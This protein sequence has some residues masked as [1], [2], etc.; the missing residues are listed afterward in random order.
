MRLWAI[1]SVACV[2]SVL[3]CPWQALAVVVWN[4]WTA[5]NEVLCLGPAAE[6]IWVGTYG[7]LVSWDRVSRAYTKFDTRDGLADSWILDVVE[8]D[9]GRVWV[10]TRGGL[11]Y[12]VGSSIFGEPPST[13]MGAGYIERLEKDPSGAIFCG[14]GCRGLL[15]YD[16]EGWHQDTLGYPMVNLPGVELTCEGERRLWL[17]VNAH[18]LCHW[19]NGV[20]TWFEP[21]G[22]DGGSGPLFFV[23]ISA[24]I[25][26]SVW[27]V[28]RDG[29]LYRVSGSDWRN[30]QPGENEAWH[31]NDVVV[32][33]SSRVWAACDEGLACYD[34]RTWRYWRESGGRALGDLRVITLDVDGEA[35]WA[36]TA[37]RGLFRFAHG[38][39]D[40]WVTNDVV[41]T[42]YKAPIT[43][44]GSELW[45][46]FYHHQVGLWQQNLWSSFNLVPG[47]GPDDKVWGIAVDSRGRKWAACN[48]YGLVV[49][50][51]GW[52][53]SYTPSNSDLDSGDVTGV[54]IDCD[55]LV[56]VSVW[57]SPTLRV[58]DGECWTA[59]ALPARLEKVFCMDCSE[60]GQRWFGGWHGAA[61][62]DG[63]EWSWFDWTNSPID[64]AVSSVDCASDGRTF[65][66]SGGLVLVVGQEGWSVLPQPD[67]P[68]FS[69]GPRDGFVTVSVDPNGRIWAGSGFSGLWVTDNDGLTWRQFTVHDSPLVD[70]W[71]RQVESDRDVVWISTLSGLSCR[72]TVVGSLQLG[73]NAEGSAGRRGAI[74]L[75]A[76]C[77]NPIG[78]VWGD[79]YLWV[80]CPDGSCYFLPS[81]SQEPER[82]A[83]K[84][85]FP[86]GLKLDHLPIFT[87]DASTVPP[88]RYMFKLIIMNRNSK[89][90]PLSNI[91][92]CEWEFEK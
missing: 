44:A 65:M 53:T 27:L 8:A 58:F 33:T 3:F 19:E 39:A 52:S 43:I 38:D 6:H 20:K 83:R 18:R 55:G 92:S 71:V 78:D 50:D 5:G 88:G 73:L 64:Y 41:G 82:L 36:G 67:M 28:S 32:D 49:F 46:G 69:G 11:N 7:G 12:V 9:D 40:W 91:A 1:V 16:E 60:D 23:D 68:G 54:M 15:W 85:R 89:T 72:R 4:D 79:V 25:S 75:R 51:E 70:N 47:A 62:F 45:A 77:E 80:E 66:V 57:A 86:D 42:S 61:C 48:G 21:P 30:V 2:V 14:T 63:H 56:W 74:S 35:I 22:A 76:S 34:G 17:I 13:L 37:R 81:L 29:L 59:P 31:V 24:D 87:C 26:G 90:E 84:V 10:A